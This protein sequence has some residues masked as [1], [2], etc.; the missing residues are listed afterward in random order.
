M[1]QGT[2]GTRRMQGVAA[3]ARSVLEPKARQSVRR[4]IRGRQCKDGGFC[5]RGGSGSDLYYTVFAA[6][7][8][9]TLRCRRPLMKTRQYVGAFG[10][11]GQLDFVHLACLARLRAALFPRDRELLDPILASM[12]RYRSADGG[13][14][15]RGPGAESG[16]AHAAFLATLT[17]AD[18]GRPLPDV[19]RLLAAVE[20]LRA[21]AGG[22]ANQKGVGRGDTNATAAAVLVR[23]QAGPVS[24]DAI[25]D[26]LLA[27][28]Q[29]EGGFL[30]HPTAPLPDLLSTATALFALRTMNCPLRDVAD[31]TV[32][33]VE[34]LWHEEGGFS[35]HIADDVA[36]CEY[37]F[38]A[39]L[40][41]G[42]LV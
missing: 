15:N 25:R 22:Y 35:G 10:A 36:D 8:L 12:E 24:D 28:Q 4:F 33:F 23:S 14:S 21:P 5:G 42:S 34:S 19:D 41:L 6:A 27:Q 9:D 7:V 32:S 31:A 2:G 26:W 18:L 39:L 3:G 16:T 17:H 20:S 29:P 1:K 30:A 38:Y 40:A 37:T 13:Y 11:G